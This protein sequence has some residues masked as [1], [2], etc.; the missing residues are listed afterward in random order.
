M[1]S[2][3]LSFFVDGLAD[4]DG[5]GYSGR[6]K[7]SYWEHSEMAIP[8]YTGMVGDEIE[9]SGRGKSEFGSGRCD[10]ASWQSS[11]GAADSTL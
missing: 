1:L 3:V 9:G 5:G 4:A 11:E 2:S 10:S 7:A 8:R 6:A